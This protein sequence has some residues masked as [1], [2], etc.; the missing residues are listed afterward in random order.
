MVESYANNVVLGEASEWPS[1]RHDG[2]SLISVREVPLTVNGE[3]DVEKPLTLTSSVYACAV[4]P[5]KNA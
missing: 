2:V 3:D 5:G 4:R 1:Y